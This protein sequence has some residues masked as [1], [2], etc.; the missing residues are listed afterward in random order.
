MIT[1]FFRQD[2]KIIFALLCVAFLLSACEKKD[3]AL[4]VSTTSKD[5]GGFARVTNADLP[6]L[7]YEDISSCFTESEEPFHPEE[8]KK[9][10]VCDHLTVKEF[11]RSED[12]ITISMETPQK[13]AIHCT[14]DPASRNVYIGLKG[15]EKT[16][17]SKFS[18]GHTAGFFDLRE[19]P[20]GDYDVLMFSDDNPA[21]L[22][23]MLFQLLPA[24]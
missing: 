19:I 10:V 5:A 4:V 17:L 21:I 15:E 24:D 6:V 3:Q 23:V 20:D 11:A 12:G 2:R 1:H 16:Y 14:W 7:E 9:S 22:S 18:H 8:E 13:L